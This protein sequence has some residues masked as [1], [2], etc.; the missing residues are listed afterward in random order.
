M[1]TNT[2]GAGTVT[3]RFAK[4]ASARHLEVIGQ[5]VFKIAKLHTTTAQKLITQGSVSG[6]G[7]VASKPGE[8]PNR[9][10]GVLDNNIEA[11]R[12]EKLKSISSSNA[13]YAAA[14]EFGNPETNLEARPYMKP[15]RIKVA[16]ELP[17]A[18][19]KVTRDIIRN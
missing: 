13:V 18:L 7:H 5:T 11:S 15:A 14:Q 3:A 16:P 9:D 2:I 1:R 6:A 10:T 4:G 19:A 8:P 17:K 12:V